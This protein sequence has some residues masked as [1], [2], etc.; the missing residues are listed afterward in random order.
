MFYDYCVWG[1]AEE[2]WPGGVFSQR[3]VRGGVEGGEGF[4]K[5]CGL[6]DFREWVGVEEFARLWVEDEGAVVK[7]DR[8]GRL[9]ESRARQRLQL[10][11]IRMKMLCSHPS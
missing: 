5:L 9:V 7:K 11:D 6:A 4:E 3:V 10:Q 2:G 1:F 8:Q